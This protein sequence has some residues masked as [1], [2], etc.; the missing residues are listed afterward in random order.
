MDYRHH[1]PLEVEKLWRVQTPP[2]SGVVIIPFDDIANQTSK[3]DGGEP[4]LRR[5]PEP[6][7][8]E[9]RKLRF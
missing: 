5:L 1:F 2:H 4:I 9:A 3:G 7:M 6:K 8:G